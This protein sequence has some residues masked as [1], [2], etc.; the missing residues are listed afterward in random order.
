VLH[1]LGGIDKAQLAVEFASQHQRKFSTVFWLDGRSKNSVVQSIEDKRLSEETL[2]G[3][4]KKGAPQ[5]IKGEEHKALCNLIQQ[6]QVM[7]RQEKDLQ[8]LEDTRKKFEQKH[9]KWQEAMNTTDLK[10]QQLQLERQTEREER[11][12]LQRIFVRQWH[13]L[14]L[15]EV[16]EWER[17]VFGN[18]EDLPSTV[19]LACLANA[20]NLPYWSRLWIIQEVLLADKVV[21]CFGGMKPEPQGTGIF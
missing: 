17:S 9:N 5:G 8:Q 2:E 20:F 7:R 10:L 4:L 15:E 14:R 11:R 21:L 19:S 3:W 18:R 16:L 13:E 12:S 6:R 1:G